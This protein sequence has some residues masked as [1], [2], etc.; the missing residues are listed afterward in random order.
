MGWIG[1]DWMAMAL[2]LKWQAGGSRRQGGRRRSNKTIWKSDKIFNN[3]VKQVIFP[4][5][6]TKTSKPKKRRK[7]ALLSHRTQRRRTGFKGQHK[8]KLL[9]NW[10]LGEEGLSRKKIVNNKNVN[11]LESF[12]FMPK[13]LLVGKA[14]SSSS[15]STVC[16]NRLCRSSMK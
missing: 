6:N 7:Q 16:M 10:E 14:A 13:L 8:Q 9:S 11:N 5:N 1:L 2:R 4:F 15:R 3:A 12:L